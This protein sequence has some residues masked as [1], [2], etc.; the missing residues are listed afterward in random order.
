[1]AAL[2]VGAVATVALA[3]LSFRSRT[4]NQPAL[5]VV[6]L[7]LGIGVA[8]LSWRLS[9]YLL[10]FY[11]PFAG[12]AILASYPR[13][14]LADVAKDLAFVIPAYIG[15]ALTEPRKQWLFPGLPLIPIVVLSAIV[16]IECFNPVLPNFL[17][18]LIGLKVWLLYLPLLVLGYR[19]V[20]SAEE[21]RRLFAILLGAATIPIVIGLLEVVWVDVFGKHDA[22]FALYGAA[23]ATQNFA[24]FNYGSRAIWRI[25]STF[26]FVAQYFS[27]TAGMM[28]VA[29]AWWRI[30]GH[31]RLGLVPLL[32]LVLAG[33]TS[34]ARGA[35]IML[36]VLIVMIVAFDGRLKLIATL[37]AVVALMLATALLLLGSGTELIIG[38]LRIGLAELHDTVIVGF[39]QTIQLGLFGHGTGSAT[40]ASR[41]AFSAERP[42]YFGGGFTLA[43]SLLESWWLRTIYELGLPGLAAAIGLF[44]VLLARGWRTMQSIRD[45]EIRAVAAAILAFLLWNL[46]YNLKGSLMNI[47]PINVYFWLLAGLMLRLGADFGRE[48]SQQAI[49]ASAPRAAA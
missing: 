3:L 45:R 31:R 33:L 40:G 41:F 12:L 37:V 16:L 32:L 38:V 14:Q 26:S 21:L 9:I 28:V 46:M 36:P 43:I 27:F 6:L 13:S 39:T 29:Y 2:V 5:G 17:V 34:G 18:P 23:A 30:S 22:V 4:I 19:L 47:D 35:L 20:S 42:L 44:A 24:Y 15:F 8:L 7:A 1:M 49:A 11:L 48:D 25:P 10:L